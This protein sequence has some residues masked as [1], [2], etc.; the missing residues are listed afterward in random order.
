MAATK[1][2]YE[3]IGLRLGSRRR[4]GRRWEENRKS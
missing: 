2:Y 4:R 1:T 3:C